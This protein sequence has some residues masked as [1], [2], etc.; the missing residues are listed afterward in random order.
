[1]ARS[2]WIFRRLS[3]RRGRLG[4]EPASLRRGYNRV[5]SFEL[6]KVMPVRTNEMRSM[7]LPSPTRRRGAACTRGMSDANDAYLPIEKTVPSVTALKQALFHQL[8]APFR[9]LISR[10]HVPEL[11][12][13]PVDKLKS[14][15]R[16][17]VLLTLPPVFFDRNAVL[18]PHGLGD[19]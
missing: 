8:D 14:K 18:L 5:L 4:A 2:R 19:R 3:L 12:D 10:R 9:R 17:W 11:P 15:K 16:V 13:E 7:Q 1:M 6:V